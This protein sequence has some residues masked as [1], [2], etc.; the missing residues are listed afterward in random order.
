MKKNF[1][2]STSPTSPFIGKLI[3]RQVV[4]VVYEKSHLSS[5]H[6][7]SGAFLIRGGGGGASLTS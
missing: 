1:N 4:P 2:I 3:D 7:H 5:T 6:T